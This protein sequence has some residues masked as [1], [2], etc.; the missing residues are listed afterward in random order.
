MAEVLTL[1]NIDD[2]HNFLHITLPHSILL[3][4]TPSNLPVGHAESYNPPKEYILTP[5]ELAKMEDQDPKDR[6]YNFIPKTH[7]CLRRVSG[8]VTAT[9][10]HCCAVLFCSSPLCTT[11]FFLTL[12][13][14]RERSQKIIFLFSAVLFFYWSLHCRSPT[15][16]CPS[17]LQLPANGIS[18]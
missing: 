11:L 18:L 8:T 10:L 3:H 17:L 13:L 1:D 15:M 16:A 4:S 6:A 9:A 7:D 2:D 14:Y 5:D 12:F